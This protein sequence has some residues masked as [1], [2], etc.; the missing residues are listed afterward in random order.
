MDP[1]VNAVQDS[2]NWFYSLPEFFFDLKKVP[3]PRPLGGFSHNSASNTLNR[4]CCHKPVATPIVT[5]TFDMA[6]FTRIAGLSGTAAIA[7]SAYGAHVL[8]Q[9]DIAENRKKV[10]ETANKTHIVHT[11]ALM[12]SHRSNFP[13]ITAGLFIAGLIFFCGPCYHYSVW[14]DERLRK[15]TPL[16][17]ILFM[18]GWLSFVL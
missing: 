6:T 1:F 10:F 16:G 4:S 13:K 12:L 5:S 14:N 18:L 3:D 7:L 11:L 2:I 9:R 8:S 17:G 15:Y